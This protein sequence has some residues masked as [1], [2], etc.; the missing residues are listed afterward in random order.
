M[1]TTTTAPR[2]IT[3]INATPESEASEEASARSTLG[4]GVGG[5]VTDSAMARSGDVGIERRGRVGDRGAESARRRSLGDRVCAPSAM[6]LLAAPSPYAASRTDASVVTMTDDAW[7]SRRRRRR[8]S[9]H[10]CVAKVDAPGMVELSASFTA[11]SSTAPYS[12]HARPVMWSA[13]GTIV[14]AAL[15]GLGVVGAGDGGAVCAV[16]GIGRRRLRRRG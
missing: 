1:P 11:T 9:A 2:T 13:M 4:A 10:A 15:V 6:S 7:S 5:S 12:A 8:A 16:V 3:T 14:I